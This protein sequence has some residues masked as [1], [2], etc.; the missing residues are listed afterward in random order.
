MLRSLV[1]SEMCIRDSVY[2]ATIQGVSVFAGASA[3][4]LAMS[5][6]LLVVRLSQSYKLAFS[7]ERR[8]SEELLVTPAYYSLAQGYVVLFLVETAAWLSNVQLLQAP[9]FGLC[10]FMD[11]I[12]LIHLSRP[13]SAELKHSVAL[14]GGL[15]L[16]LVLLVLL[17]R[18]ER[19][20]HCDWC[21]MHFPSKDVYYYYTPAAVGFLSVALVATFGSQHWSY[22]PRPAACSFGLFMGSSYGLC[23][24]GLWILDE[25]GD[26]LGYCCLDVALTGY[27]ILYAPML[28]MAFSQDS[29]LLRRLEISQQLEYTAF[30]PLLQGDACDDIKQLMSDPSIRLVA[31][32]EITLDHRIGCGGFGEVFVGRWLGTQVALKRILPR[33]DQTNVLHAFLGELKILSQLRHPHCVLLLGVCISPENECILT[34]YMPNQS[35]FQLLHPPNKPAAITVEFE[36]KQR[37]FESCAS[38]MCYLHSHE[39]QIVHRDLKSSNLLMDH[40]GTIKVCD[41]GLATCRT[42]G[43]ATSTGCTPQWAAPEVLREDAFSAGSD[44]YSFGVIIW[45]LL[46][47]LIPFDQFQPIRVAHEVA[48]NNLTPPRDRIWAV[49]QLNPNHKALDDMVGVMLQCWD[50]DPESRPTMASMLQVAGTWSAPDPPALEPRVVW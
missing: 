38:G 28:Y 23:S 43:T 12:L 33:S 20:H 46:T 2:S 16:T 30:A 10:F 39:P 36:I 11:C 5:T 18:P 42:A 37:I 34:E 41:F 7:R 13:A 15:S 14:S 3:L 21:G 29:Q 47:E 27:A 1:G 19:H 26:D 24:I 6:F 8:L 44:C 9:I 25:Y 32:S 45:E 22:K 50:P 48:Y 49:S 17:V 40:D 31:P 35:C 4:V